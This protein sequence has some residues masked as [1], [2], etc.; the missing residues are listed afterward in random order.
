VIVRVLEVDLEDVVVDVDDR[1]LDFDSLVAEE[2]KLHHRHRPGRVL[3]QGLVDGDRDLGAG[4]E[5]PSD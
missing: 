2:L 4:S 5:L 1:G 3:G